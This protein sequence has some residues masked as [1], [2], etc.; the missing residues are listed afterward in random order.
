MQ[1][2]AHAFVFLAAAGST[3][4]ELPALNLEQQAAVRCGTAFAIVTALQER[5]GA[6]EIAPL[7]NRGNEYFVRSMAKVMDETGAT[8]EQI[9][10]L[11]QREARELENPDNLGAV[12]PA[13]LAMLDASGL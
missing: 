3:A 10:E 7:G 4:G 2:I 11:V 5:G 9:Q 6:N 13:C 1:T 8:R 12:M